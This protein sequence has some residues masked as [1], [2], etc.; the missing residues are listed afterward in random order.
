MRNAE[1]FVAQSF[2]A[3]QQWCNNIERDGRVVDNLANG[4]IS[5]RKQRLG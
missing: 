3:G 1:G 5:S 4:V 2:Q